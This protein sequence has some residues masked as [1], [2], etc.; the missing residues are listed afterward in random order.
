V[1]IYCAEGRINRAF[2]YGQTLLI[3]K[4]VPKPPEKGRIKDDF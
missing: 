4:N 3:P 2:K 1:Q